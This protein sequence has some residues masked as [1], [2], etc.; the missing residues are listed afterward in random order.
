M[1]PLPLGGRLYVTPSS[2]TPFVARF[3]RREK[4]PSAGQTA[5]GV[6]MVYLTRALA[7]CAKFAGVTG[8]RELSPDSLAFCDRWRDIFRRDPVARDARG[9]VLRALLAK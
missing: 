6:I 7:L 4:R 3:P 1:V 2:L 5:L 8:V 9:E